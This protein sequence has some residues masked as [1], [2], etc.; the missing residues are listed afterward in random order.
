VSSAQPSPHAAQI[1]LG[2]EHHRQG[3]WGAAQAIYQQILAQEPTCAEALHLLGMLCHETGRSGEAIELVRRS[4]ELD[5]SQPHVL[6]NY[7]S[8]LAK[9]G[10]PH[11][12]LEPIREALRLAP[13][14]AEAHNNLGATLERLGRWDE[15]LAA[16]DR[17]IVLNPQY[18][19]AHTHRG[20]VLRW[21]GNID[22]S[23]EAYKTALR[24]R[25]DHGLA[26]SGL[27]AA[28]GE[29]GDVEAIIRCQRVVLKSWP[30]PHP[31]AAKAHSD[32]LY[33]LHYDPDQTPQQLFDEHQ[34]WA[35]LHAAPLYPRPLQ[36]PFANTPVPD[37]RLRIGY[38]SAD[39]RSHPVATFLWGALAHADRRQ[40][41]IYCYSDVRHGDAVTARFRG[42]VDRWRETAILSDQRLAQQIRSDGI[43]ILVDQAGHAAGNRMLVFARR[44]APV[45]VTFNGYI[46]TTGLRT[47]DYRLTDAYHDPPEANDQFYTERLLRIPGGLWCY[48]PDLDGEPLP[49]VAPPPVVEKGYI[50][51]GCLNKV[52]KMNRLVLGLWSRLLREL[53][54]ARL[55]V[56]LAGGEEYNGGVRRKFQA[57]GIPANRL[58]ILA[59][60]RT[61]RGYLER[62]HQIDV[63]LD[64]FPFNGMTTTCD[65]LLMG[66]PVV[67]LAGRTHV[68]RSGV[69]FLNMAGLSEMVA[70]SPDQYIAVAMDLAK[71]LPRLAAERSALREQLLSSQLCNQDRFASKLDRV[72]RLMWHA[73]CEGNLL[74]TVE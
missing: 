1:S 37:R 65:A 40:Y 43:D 38:V 33:T 4:A 42:A 73:W 11:E 10:R 47:M 19:E 69:S 56:A 39:F 67:T 6:S 34:H 2:L 60:T 31:S 62:Y 32:L 9:A 27:G 59:K 25:P 26:L 7:G 63:A 49:G 71:D 66:V 54:S 23:I 68:S 22:A 51:F 29:A 48:S 45:Q 44:P 15:A 24:L 30:P 12:A 3:R 61:R 55:I 57:A 28:Y 17:A 13:S 14:F 52:V 58:I 5:P 70:E 8:L 74:R 64:T 50:T 16:F 53:P 46:D 41:E 35:Q 20:N 72:Y 36:V 21:F 18:V